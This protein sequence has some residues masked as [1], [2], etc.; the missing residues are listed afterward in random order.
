M[1]RTN[2]GAL[3]EQTRELLMVVIGAFIVAAVT[4]AYL[5]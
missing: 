1:L 4:L 5:F 3:D 2:T